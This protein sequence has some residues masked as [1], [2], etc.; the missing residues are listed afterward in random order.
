MSEI[1][2]ESDEKGKKDWN[3]I[4]NTD[5]TIACVSIDFL[6]D[7]LNSDE[8]VISP[9][10]IKHITATYFTFN[11][12]HVVEMLLGSENTSLINLLLFLLKKNWIIVGDDTVI[13][14]L[15]ERISNISCGSSFEIGMLAFSQIL[16]YEIA[17][18]NYKNEECYMQFVNMMPNAF[19]IQDVI[20]AFAFI[21]A[22]T[23]KI[24]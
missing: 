19:H 18:N 9:E 14:I 6:L 3:L 12:Q 13:P 5:M 2:K 7:A 8:S 10:V 23:K 24:H 21:C 15:L 16:S 22:T 20:K 4:P 17:T 11:L 1:Y